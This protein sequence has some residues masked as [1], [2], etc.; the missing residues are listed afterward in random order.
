M[1]YCKFIWNLQNQYEDQAISEKYESA[2]KKTKK[3]STIYNSSHP[4]NI[5]KI[6]DKNDLPFGLL[7]EIERFDGIHSQKEILDDII[8]YYKRINQPRISMPPG[9]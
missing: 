3:L 2:Y 7:A 1:I 5:Q 9:I 8:A 6:K 4:R